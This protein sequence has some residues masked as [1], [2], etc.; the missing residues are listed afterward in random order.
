M[1]AMSADHGVADIPEI[2]G[3]GGRL[4]TKEVKDALEKVFV[5]VLGAGD[6]VVA[7]VYTDV[8]LTP[9]TVDRMKADEA[10][11]TAAMDALLAL[12]AVSR[13]FAGGGAGDG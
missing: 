12:P 11:R 6:H 3:A 9:T 7:T 4:T 1:L 8:Y 5:P 2:A 13:V 10:L